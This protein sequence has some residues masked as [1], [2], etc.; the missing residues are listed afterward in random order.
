MA[1]AIVR[2]GLSEVENFS[3][4]HGIAGNA[5]IMLGAGEVLGDRQWTDAAKAAADRGIERHERLRVPGLVGCAMARKRRT[6]SGGPPAS[7]VV[8]FACAPQLTFGPA[9]GGRYAPTGDARPSSLSRGQPGAV[10]RRG[11]AHLRAPAPTPAV[12]AL[13]ARL[14]AEE[15]RNPAR[16]PR[17]SDDTPD[18]P[19]VES[20]P[21]CL[22]GETARAL[23]VEGKR[24]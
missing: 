2:D 24:D 3:L 18:N 11:I 13:L 9:A 19:C 17:Y 22:P 16:S 5:D 10:Q 8:T 12:P 7:G 4:C 6:R 21:M 14:V 20:D 1:L 23:A 15:S